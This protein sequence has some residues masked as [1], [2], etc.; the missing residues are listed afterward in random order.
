M[1]TI[2]INK[3]CCKKPSLLALCLKLYLSASSR[4]GD[5]V[6]I[7]GITFCRFLVRCSYLL[8][9][10]LCFLFLFVE[11]PLSANHIFF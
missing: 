1:P 10:I 5:L 4:K 7:L 11:D 2:I 8:F 3:T 9:D 6:G